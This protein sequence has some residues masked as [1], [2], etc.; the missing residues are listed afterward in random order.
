MGRKATLHSNTMYSLAS[1][2]IA[3]MEVGDVKTI[4]L[5]ADLPFFRKYLSEIGKREGKRFT[6]RTL[7]EGLQL[8]RVKYYNIHSHEIEE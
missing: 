7:P 5:P 8:M 4:A 2:V 3:G 6:T 1:Q